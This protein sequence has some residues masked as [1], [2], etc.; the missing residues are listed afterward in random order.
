VGSRPFVTVHLAQSLDGRVAL[1]GATTALSTPEGRVCAHAERAAHDAVLVGSSTVRIDDP[2]LTVREVAGE[3]PLRVVLASTLVLPRGARA[4]VADGRAFVIGAEGCASDGERAALEAAGVK[5]LLAPRGADGRVSIEGAL[6]LLAE[7]GVTRLLVEGGSK[8][9]TSFLRA[10]CVDRMSIELAMRFLGAPGTP[11]LG[12]L[13]V[14]ALAQAPS[15]ANVSIERLGESVLVR[16]DV[17][18]P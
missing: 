11:M 12:D 4:L 14:G 15:L 9:V 2:R 3:Q 5:V 7:R 16:G 1:E 6:A 13:A 8:V 10:R 17:V 18:Y